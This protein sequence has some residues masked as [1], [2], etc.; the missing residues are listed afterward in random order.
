MAGPLIEFVCIAA[1]HKPHRSGEHASTV[2][3]HEG[4]WAYCDS[5]AEDGH[6]WVASGGIPLELLRYRGRS[7][8]AAAR[9]A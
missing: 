1:A 2:T 5:P 6:D 3:V 9:P 4:R 8:E 7:P